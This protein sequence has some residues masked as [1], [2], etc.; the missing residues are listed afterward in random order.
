MPGKNRPVEGN[1]L[2]DLLSD[3][4]FVPGETLY[5]H[6]IEQVPA[7][8]YIDSNEPV[9]RTLYV[10]PQVEELFGRKPEEWMAD[11]ALWDEA[12]HPDDFPNVNTTWLESIRTQSPCLLEYRMRRPDG[13]Y[14]WIRDSCTPV[15]D[16]NGETLYWHG[17]LHDVTAAKEVEHSLRS[18]EARYRALVENLPAVV[19]VVA[20]DD[21]RK[22]LYVSPQVEVALGYSREEWLEQPDIWMELLHPDDREQ[23]LAAHDRHNET[24]EQW[25]REY[26]LIASDGRAVWFRDVATLVRDDDG[27]PIH[28]EGVQ[29]D[30]TELKRIE[31]ELRAASDELELRVLERT[32]ELEEANELMMLEIEERRRVERELREAR[33]RYRLLAEHLPGVAYVWDMRAARDETV[34]VSP[35]IEKM[36]GFTKEE[37]GRKDFWRTRVH[38]DDRRTVTANA[39]RSA[40]KGEPF[41]MEYRYLAKDGRVVWVLDEA[42]LLERDDAGRPRIFHGLMLDITDRKLA[43][44]RAVEHELRYKMLASQIPAVTYLW[45]PTDDPSTHGRTRYVSDQVRTVFGFS[46]EEWTS[47][48]DFWLDQ[49]HPDDREH[50]GAVAREVVRSGRPF[51]LQYRVIAANGSTVWVRDEGRVVELDDHGRPSVW[52]GIMLDVTEHERTQQ[53]LRAAESRFRTLV[54]QIPAIVYIELPAPSAAEPR[55]V[56]M[57]PQVEPILGYTAEELTSEPRHF[58]RMLHPEDRDR[59]LAANELSDATGGPFDE[60]YRVLAKDGRTVWIHSRASLV[61]D[62]RGNPLYWQGVALDVTEQHEPA[63]ASPAGRRQLA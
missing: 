46:P 63:G 26:R 45:Q 14:I 30:I 50:V 40:V 62:E 31:E 49:L 32:H 15:R 23:T 24:G 38:P 2:D 12:I 34:Y 7:V 37:W 42:I 5:R 11:R 61:R 27:R 55:L 33:E 16:A 60:E 28:W 18:S 25:S 39:L 41:S 6:L 10:S 51:S 19:Y 20:P 1:G 36:L 29:L 59:V 44:A 8:V 58:V 53:E 48:P 13:S 52:Q 3:G 35:Q 56:Y 54:E 43:E 47:R 4:T 21:D 9:S 57:S 17:V 22:T